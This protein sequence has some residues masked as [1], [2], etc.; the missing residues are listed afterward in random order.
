[1]K[2]FF[3]KFENGGTHV[4]VSGAGVVKTAPNKENAIKFIEFLASKDAQGLFA[5]GNFEYPVL[6]G[7]EP[8][9]LVKSWG[10]F[11]D[12]KISINTL[13]ENNAKAVKIFDLAGWK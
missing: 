9:D 7:I 10:S 3:P 5:A 11:E 1:M 2:I 4:N 13:G 12:D 8:S 6:A